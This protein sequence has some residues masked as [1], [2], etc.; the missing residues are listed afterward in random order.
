[1]QDQA[2]AALTRATLTPFALVAAACLL[3][4]QASKVWALRALHDGHV[5]PL[6]GDL[7]SLRLIRNPGAAF[8]LGGSS[9]LV[10]TGLAVVI[11]VVVAVAA[12]RTRSVGWALSLGALFGGS[13]GNLYDRFFREPAPGKG[14]VIDFIDYGG[15]FVGNIA[16]VAIVLGAAGLLW[17]SFTD[18]GLDGVKGGRHARDGEE[19]GVVGAKGEDRA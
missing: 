19:P 5:V 15:L 2:G 12:W 17:L 3:A 18:V 8:S 10:M 11:T 7:L 9:T 14:H 4:D 13:L 16:D 1:M 6:L